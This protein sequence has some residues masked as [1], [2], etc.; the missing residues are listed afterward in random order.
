MLR[1]EAKLRRRYGAQTMFAQLLRKL[2]FIFRM[3]AIPIIRAI[4]IIFPLL[5][6]NFR[7]SSPLYDR[8]WLR[9]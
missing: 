7:V 5:S 9:N 3:S 8:P 1:A 2:A 4:A 6:G